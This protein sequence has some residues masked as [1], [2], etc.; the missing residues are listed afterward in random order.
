MF[1]FLFLFPFPFN[2]K[3]FFFFLS[4]FLVFFF[5]FFFLHPRKQYIFLDFFTVLTTHGIVHGNRALF[6]NFSW[7]YS[8]W[9]FFHFFVF[10]NSLYS[11]L[12]F[13]YFALFLLYMWMLQ[14]F[15]TI[16]II[17][18]I[19]ICTIHINNPFLFFFFFFCKPKRLGCCSIFFLFYFTIDVNIIYFYIFHL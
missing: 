12:F 15:P 17:S 9:I 6:F 13:C 1:F 19:F 4:I 11:L 2:S 3:F 14:F 16:H 8:Q 10:M 5:S 7:H 18:A